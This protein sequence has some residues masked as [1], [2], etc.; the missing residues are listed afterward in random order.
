M[1]I[2]KEFYFIRHGQTDYN[3][4]EHKV[5]YVDVSL[6]SVGLQQAQ[7]LEPLVATLPIRSI[8]FSPLKRA[9]ETK[10]SVA[11]RLQA[12]QLEIPELG[13]CSAQVW[14]EMTQFGSCPQI[15][16]SSDHVKAFIQRTLKGINQALTCE[17]PVLIVAHGGIHWAMCYL[18]G[19]TDHTWSIGNCLPVHFFTSDENQWKAKILRDLP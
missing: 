11:V 14:N 16:H 5:D 17:G 6:N 8:C 4:S 13:E 7:S 15:Q 2:K 12:A 1:I 19:I 18:M 9:K 10:E 3:V